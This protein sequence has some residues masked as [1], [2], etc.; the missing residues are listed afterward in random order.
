MQ[1]KN[2]R[3]SKGPITVLALAQNK[4]YADLE[5]HLMRSITIKGETFNVAHL[6]P[7]QTFA[8]CFATHC[9]N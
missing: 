7:A 9:F 4:D 5:A 6:A 3:S 1:I 2:V 8:A